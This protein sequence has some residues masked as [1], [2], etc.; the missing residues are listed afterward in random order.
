MRVKKGRSFGPILRKTSRADSIWS[1][2]RARVM[3]RILPLRMQRNRRRHGT[4]VATNVI[5]AAYVRDDDHEDDCFANRR[6]PVHR[7]RGA[8][9]SLAGCALVRAVTRALVADASRAGAQSGAWHSHARHALRG[10]RGVSQPADARARARVM[11]SAVARVAGTAR[12]LS[13]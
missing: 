11:R 3:T 5:A 2:A 7:A 6:R 1:V 13:L 12:N 9:H 10:R 4:P 8:D